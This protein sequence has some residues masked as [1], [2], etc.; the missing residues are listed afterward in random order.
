MLISKEHIVEYSV[1]SQFI[2]T[3]VPKIKSNPKV[4]DALLFATGIPKNI[5]GKD[6]TIK[7]RRDGK[8]GD[9]LADVQARTAIS[10]G[11]PPQIVPFD[12]PLEIYGAFHTATPAYIYINKSWIDKFQKD[13]WLKDAQKLILATV[14]HEIVHYLDYA[15]DNSF[16]DCK[17]DDKDRGFVFEELAY[18]S[19]VEKW[20]SPSD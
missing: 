3:E 9:K 19:R 12:L 2:L 15:K 17:R 13:S 16:L 4:W 7:Y 5:S 10:V 1:F 20:Q 14:L 6:A 18:D 11:M 8:L